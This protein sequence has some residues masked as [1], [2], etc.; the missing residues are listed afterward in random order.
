MR[1]AEA[2]ARPKGLAERRAA[3]APSSPSGLEE[4]CL[5]SKPSLSLFRLCFL[6]VVLACARPQGA[7]VT[8]QRGG[9]GHRRRE[10]AG[11]GA[12]Q[13]VRAW[14]GW[15]ICT[16]PVTGRLSV[17]KVT[18]LRERGPWTY[19]AG[20]QS[21]PAGSES[22][23]AVRMGSAYGTRVGRFRF[24]S[25]PVVRREVICRLCLVPLTCGARSPH[26]RNDFD[27]LE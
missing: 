4:G 10:E 14:P 2:P 7:R 20:S 11:R 8:C 3:S 24:D 21:G 23:K 27:V 25:A 17:R 5:R 19:G 9:R 1:R 15:P 26:V 13:S 12:C 18:V 16:H 6:G 22:C